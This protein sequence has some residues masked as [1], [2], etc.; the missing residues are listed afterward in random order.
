MMKLLMTVTHHAD[1]TVERHVQTSGD[2]SNSSHAAA[3]AQGPSRQQRLTGGSHA[4]A[5]LP[6][7]PNG[8]EATMPPKRQKKRTKV[9]K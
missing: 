9:K 6:Q 2:G 7:P 1:G 4:R 8:G 3:L 5:S